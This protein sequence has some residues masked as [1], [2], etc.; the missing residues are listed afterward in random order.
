MCVCVC[1]C[2]WVCGCGCVCVCVCGWVGGCVCV[3]GCVSGEMFKKLIIIFLYTKSVS[4][5]EAK[6]SQISI[7]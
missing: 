1:V 5:T 7:Y 2:G 3:C 6:S 4:N